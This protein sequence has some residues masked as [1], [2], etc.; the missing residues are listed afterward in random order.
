MPFFLIGAFCLF[1]LS[2]NL[3]SS[4]KRNLELQSIEIA[5]LIEDLLLQRSQHLSLLASLYEK[6]PQLLQ[7]DGS[8]LKE[9]AQKTNFLD[10]Y[11]QDSQ[12]V[13]VLS[14]S[15]KEL[16]K[17][18]PQGEWMPL[19]LEGKNYFGPYN[20]SNFS[21]NPGI[22]FVK[23]LKDPQ[24]NVFGALLG[25]IS[26]N[27]IEETFFEKLKP[28]FIPQDPNH[29]VIIQGPEAGQIIYATPSS[30]SLE[31]IQGKPSEY[32]IGTAMT[33][34]RD[35]LPNYKW[36]VFLG[37]PSSFFLPLKPFLGKIIW[38]LFLLYGA[39]VCSIF[40]M[41]WNNKSILE[42]EL[43]YRSI[44]GATP[45]PVLTFNPKDGKIIEANL[46]VCEILDLPQRELIGQSVWNYFN[47]QEDKDYLEQNLSK[48]NIL[49]DWEVSMKS[50]TGRSF[51]AG[52]SARIID[53]GGTTAG[54]IG[55][56][57]ITHRKEIE[58]QL[59]YNAQHLEKI[60]EMRTQ[61]LAHKAGELERTNEE[62]EK[63]RLAAELANSS[64]SQFLANMS[65]ELRTPLNA[66]I[67]Y[68][69]ILQEEAQANN[70]ISMVDDLVKINNAGK[71]LLSLINDVLDLS[72]IEAGKMELHLE[73]FNIIDM[74]QGVEGI[75]KPLIEKKKNHLTIECPP[76][77][78][79]M[80]SDLTKMRQN[81][82]NLLSNASKFTENGEITL[83]ITKFEEK[84]REWLHFSVIDTGIGM[85]PEQVS[86]MFQAFTQADA[87][88][89]RKYGGTGLG[90][91]ITR[92]FCQLLGGDA[93]VSSVYGQGSTFT[94]LVPV[95]STFVQEQKNQ[96]KLSY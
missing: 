25:L 93:T 96:Q 29:F 49:R 40:F 37:T 64:K 74:I 32:L 62:L 13:I 60:V 86:R 56:Y 19:I 24:E 69:E 82:F 58:R 70:I 6:T 46:P 79:P 68:S 50:A 45:I 92:K 21:L 17:R 30:P 1:F 41:L 53:Y 18:M 2:L 88:T 3:T 78:G 73:S 42:N 54:I 75:V 66:V 84:E 28:T 63:A 77:I 90:L 22:L 47:R 91:T 71:H 12:G 57:D 23:P 72:K 52:L 43:K 26:G 16:G 27:E 83:R 55:F 33:Q 87:S 36:K 76:D 8:I 38:F 9:A 94:L 4:I 31:V 39:I 81:L 65:H 14:S 51:W 59:E 10:F 7:M 67:G 85:T 11:I 61:D 89:T 95:D 15:S 48:R 80:T 20:G 35:L 5:N 44:A 34:G